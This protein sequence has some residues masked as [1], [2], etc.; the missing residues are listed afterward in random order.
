MAYRLRVQI[1]VEKAIW[2]SAREQIITACEL[3]SHASIHGNT[4]R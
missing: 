1:S 3:Q 4:L 2:K